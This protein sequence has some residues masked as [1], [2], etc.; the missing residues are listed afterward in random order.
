MSQAALGSLTNSLA[1]SGDKYNDL[2]LA[3]LQMKNAVQRV[4][5]RQIDVYSTR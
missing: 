5:E 4:V 1:K 3:F 2:P